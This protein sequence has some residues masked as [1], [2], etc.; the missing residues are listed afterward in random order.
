MEIDSW[1]RTDIG[2]LRK[3]M[4][5]FNLDHRL[6]SLPFLLVLGLSG[7]VGP[8]HTSFSTSV[9]PREYG[10]NDPYVSVVYGR[11]ASGIGGTLYVVSPTAEGVN[12]PINS[13][14]SGCFVMEIEP[15]FY[16][17]QPYMTRLGT[18]EKKWYNSGPNNWNPDIP[19]NAH[20]DRTL[21]IH[22]EEDEKTTGL[23]FIGQAGEILYIGD[24][25]K[26]GEFLE[27]TDQKARIDAWMK[28]RFA[29]F[30]PA[31]TRKYLAK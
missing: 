9:V 6:L 18:G 8:M 27:S 31:A 12:Y 28:K 30:N 19:R 20:D 10:F 14:D 22:T 5:Y 25:T 11:K 2:Y 23:N 29:N 17:V 15:G 26:Q 24:I 13:G 7:C 4:L 21:E 3:S 16:R 1:I